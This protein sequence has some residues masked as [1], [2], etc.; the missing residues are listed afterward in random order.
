MRRQRQKSKLHVH[1]RPYKNTIMEIVKHKL[2][3]QIQITASI[4][5]S[6]GYFWL[7]YDYLSSYATSSEQM[8]DFAVTCLSLELY[9]IY[10]HELI[11]HTEWFDH[12]IL[13]NTFVLQQC[14]Q[15]SVKIKSRISK[16]AQRHKLMGRINH[17]QQLGHWRLHALLK[18][19]IVLT[20]FDYLW[21]RLCKLQY[22]PD[23]TTRKFRFV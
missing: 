8:E 18:N 11:L 6:C 19:N 15:S 9:V 5:I 4:F 12:V 16:V 23:Y 10:L 20:H 17:F 2:S 3:C 1:P 21:I 13:Q 7:T 22:K 14:L